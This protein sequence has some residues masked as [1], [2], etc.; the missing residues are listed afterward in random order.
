MVLLGPSGCGKSTALRMIAGLEEV[1]DG[2]LSIGNRVVNNIPPRERD[3]AMVFQ[4]YALYPHMSVRKNI[5]SPLVA[6]RAN[7]LPAGERSE[8]IDEAAEVLGLTDYLDRKPG[9]LS[10]GQRQ[11]VALARA[12]VRRPEVFLMDEPLSTLED[13]KSVV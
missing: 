7:R 4:S 10:G 5:E 12:I 11:R 3:I 13:R 1:S 9:E 8:R 6:N 2:M